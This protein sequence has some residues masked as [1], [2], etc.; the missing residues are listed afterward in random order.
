IPRPAQTTSGAGYF[1]L[2]RRTSIL[3][4]AQ[5]AEDADVASVAKGLAEVL[6]KAAGSAFPVV[7]G[8]TRK[9]A[10]GFKLDPGV[11]NPE[12]YRLHVDPFGI[13]IEAQTAR[14]LF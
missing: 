6:R 4:N 11:A 7:K 14:G 8:G 3:W 2:G 10:I 12:G 13:E 9:G 5:G 1:V